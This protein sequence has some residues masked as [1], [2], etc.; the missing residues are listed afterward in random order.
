MPND[1]PFYVVLCLFSLA[2]A[3]FSVLLARDRIR[4]PEAFLRQIEPAAPPAQTPAV[5]LSTWRVAIDARSMIGQ[6][7]DDRTFGIGTYLKNLVLQL[8]D[9]DKETQ[10]ILWS[11]A[12][13]HGTPTWYDEFIRSRQNFRGVHV[14]LPNR[15]VDRA[16]YSTGLHFLDEL[17]GRVDVS[18]EVNYFPLRPAGAYSICTVHDLA[19]RDDRFRRRLR[20]E[21]AAWQVAQ[22]DKITTVS[23]ASKKVILAEVKGVREDQL[24]VVYGA[25]DEQF[26]P[27]FAKQELKRVRETHGLPDRYFVYVGEAIARKNLPTLIHGFQMMRAR[28]PE[29][30]LLMV[31]FGQDK[32]LDLIRSTDPTCDPANVRAIGYVPREDLPSLYHAARALVWPSRDEGFGLPL[33]EAMSTGQM[34]VT[35]NIPAAREI[36][37]GVAIFFDPDR[38]DDIR[39]RLLRALDM[40]DEER[41]DL[42]E[43][44]VRRVN[45]RYSWEASARAMLDLFAR[46]FRARAV[47]RGKGV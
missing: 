25:A 19:F 22:A 9:Q 20:T 10:Y 29:V 7:A 15:F 28:S 2:L 41:T 45:E 43:A 39:D 26:N 31:G 23:E 18:Y 13:K 1:L 17:I 36:A 5:R 27:T 21:R 42:I 34:I 44:G 24:E 3:A 33:V 47:R 30:V 8:A 4:F 37:E 32:L 35:S 46:G 11:S 6:S 40:S 14:R 12:L 38:P 16:A